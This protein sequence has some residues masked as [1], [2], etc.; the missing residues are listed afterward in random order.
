MGRIGT[1]RRSRTK[2]LENRDGYIRNSLQHTSEFCANKLEFDESI[3]AGDSIKVNATIPGIS[4][5][6]I[7][8]TSMCDHRPSRGIVTTKK[9]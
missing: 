4:T 8:R 2:R 9:F 3:T 7:T 6:K 5:F 1:P